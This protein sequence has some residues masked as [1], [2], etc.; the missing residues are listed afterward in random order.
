MEHEITIKFTGQDA[1]DH[2]LPAY[3]AS[4]MMYGISRTFLMSLS[5]LKNGKVKTRYLEDRHYS[6]DIVAHE[7]G[8]FEYTMLLD[9]AHEHMDFLKGLGV[10]VSANFAYDV[11]KTIFLR[12]VGSQGITSVE[13]RE[14]SGELNGGDLSALED[15]IA[16]A[17]RNGHS[18]IGNGATNVAIISGDGN[19]INFN[20]ET[21]EYLSNTIVSDSDL[22]RNFSVGIF[23]PNTG[24]GKLFDYQEGRLVSFSLPK[25]V[26][27]HT[28]STII[29][30]Q[31]FYGKK[32][33]L[34]AEVDPR[35]AIE[36][37]SHN[38]PNGKVKKI[39]VKKARRN[40]S[41]L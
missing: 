28:R 10:G 9:Y 17:L 5:Y 41:D 20:Q 35:I 2:R 21:K 33:L 23:N 18:L 27:W 13:R 14:V 22:Q 11:V 1:E 4:K 3:A 7:P 34:A 29:E 26:D 38:A 36:Y 32:I 6:F 30:S 19:T 40:F 39:I 8:S 24:N 12:S 31:N 15:K 16:P 25:D 37:T